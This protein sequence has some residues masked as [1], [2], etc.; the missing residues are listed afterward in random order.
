VV[1]HAREHLGLQVNKLDIEEDRLPEGPFDAVTMWGLLQ[2]VYEPRRLLEDARRVLSPEGVL[3]IGVSNF[4]S[5]GASLFGKSWRGLGLPRHLIHFTPET[6]T[7]LVEWCG[8]EVVRLEFETPR[9]IVSGS[10]DAI[11]S[12]APVRKATKAALYGVAAAVGRTPRAD[13]MELY[14]RVRDHS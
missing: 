6:L 5:A 7:R 8:F 14:A 4:R 9:W 12:S 3:A 13:T 11:A 2:L 10:V 1:W